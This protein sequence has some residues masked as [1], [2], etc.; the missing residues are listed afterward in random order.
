MRARERGPARRLTRVRP[1]FF[2]LSFSFYGIGFNIV[3]LLV[4]ESRAFQVAAVQA[5]GCVRA[6][7]PVTRS[8][9]AALGVYRIG[10]EFRGRAAVSNAKSRAP[11]EPPAPRYAGRAAAATLHR[12]FISNFV[13]RARA[14]FPVRPAL[15]FSLW[16][17]C[18]IQRSWRAR[19][20][21]PDIAVEI[22]M[23]DVVRESDSFRR[24][25]LGR[26]AG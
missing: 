8:R 13:T 6:P 4:A 5:R 12:N 25:A 1:S 10:I 9:I 3:S 24:G 7:G 17:P 2:F 19:A 23:G 15:R 16:I 11:A 14:A 22:F 26:N 20:R 18:L 21:V